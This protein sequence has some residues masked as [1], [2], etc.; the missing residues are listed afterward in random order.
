MKTPHQNNNRFRKKSSQQLN[1]VVLG[2]IVRG[3]LGG[4]AWHHLQYVLALSKLGHNVTFIEDSDEYASC[5]NPKKCEFS[6]DPA[7]GLAFARQS[8]AL[9]G[10]HQCW[11]YYDAH[12]STWHGPKSD[13]A[14]SDCLHADLLLNLSGINPMRP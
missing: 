9:L 14:Q 13:T 10:L 12:I 4:L 2:Y 6:T 8:F 5:F 1:I 3:P 7:Y 11:A